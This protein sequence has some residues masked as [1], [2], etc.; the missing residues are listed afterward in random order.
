M[1]CRYSDAWE[2][3]FF[4]MT[5]FSSIRNRLDKRRKYRCPRPRCRRIFF[6]HRSVSQHLRVGQCHE[7]YITAGVDFSED[8]SS[9]DGLTDRDEAEARSYHC[10]TRSRPGTSSRSGSCKAQTRTPMEPRMT[11]GYDEYHPL[12]SSTFGRG[13]NI[14]ERI[15]LADTYSELRH[16]N[17]YYP[18]STKRD[19]ET[20]SWLSRSALSVEKVNEYLQLNRVS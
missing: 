18:F 11:D 12:A 15:K 6:T 7:W 2:Y 4:L 19:W 17:R 1:K 3:L 8:S 20:A 5:S 10:P 14:F 13:R 16:R 9:S